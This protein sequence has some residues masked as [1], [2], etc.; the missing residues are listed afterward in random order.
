[1]AITNNADV[2]IQNASAVYCCVRNAKRITKSQLVPAT[3]L[4]F[5]SVSNLCN[6]LIDKKLLSSDSNFKN[7]GGRKAAMVNFNSDFGYCLV[8][9]FHH[10]EHFSIGILNFSCEILQRVDIPIKPNQTLENLMDNLFSAYKDMS[11][12]LTSRVL[13]VVVAVSAVCAIDASILIQSS[14]PIFEG[15]NIKHVFESSF[16]NIPII[17][18][19]DANIASLSQIN[20]VESKNKDYLFV[21]LTQGVGMGIVIDGTVYRGFNGYAG[22]L[23]HFKVQGVDKKCKCGQ[24][25]CLRLVATLES[26]AIDLN[27][28]NLL[29]ES[30]D[31][32]QYAKLLAKRYQDG[33]EAVIKRID[34]AARKLGEVFSQLF[35][36]FNPSV[37]YA[38]GNS[39]PLFPYF[40]RIVAQKCRECSKL[41]AYYELKVCFIDQSS[42]NLI[43]LGGGRRFF[44]YWLDNKFGNLFE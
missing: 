17:V 13:G 32:V 44:Y 40:R 25:G 29:H 12:T 6:L 43:L 10:T 35:D 15:V 21:L 2:R 33:E 22:E 27:E 26:I 14:N 23:G 34:L 7:T 39:W 41:A 5:A 31:A 28:T 30:L 37:I 1:M 24:V 16:P 11:I 18:D 20:S 19:N 3:G 8:V 38:G 4:S 36:I 42:T 9:D